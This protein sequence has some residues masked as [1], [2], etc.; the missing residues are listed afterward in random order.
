MSDYQTGLAGCEVI[1]DTA[2]HTG[3]FYCIQVIDDAVL[4]TDD[5][6]VKSGVTNLA[7][8]DTITLDAG[9]RIYMPF[10]TIKLVSGLVI[11]YKYHDPDA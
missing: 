1:D 10:T 5:S 9:I 8:L 3:S 7:G 6:V 11:A 2:E 4:N